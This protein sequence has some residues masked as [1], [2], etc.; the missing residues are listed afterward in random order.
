MGLLLGRKPEH[1]T[2]CFPFEVAGGG[3]EGQLLCEAVLVVWLS[4]AAAACVILLSFAAGHRKSYWSGCIKAAILICQ[5]IFSILVLMIFFL[6]F[7]E[8]VR[9]NRVFLLWRQDPALELQFLTPLQFYCVLQFNISISHCNGCG[10][11]AWCRGCMRNTIVFCS[12]TSYIALEWLHQGCDIDL[13]AEFLNFG[14]DDF[15]FL[16]PFKK[17]FKFFFRSGAGTHP[18]LELQFLLSLC[19][20]TFL[21]VK[22]SL[23]KSLQA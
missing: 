5:Q 15:P 14:V 19:T 12:W 10:K 13:S 18:I 2:L 1:E 23:C 16:I 17:C 4:G 8:K 3:D 6:K 21:R 11:V 22:T 7:L 9:Q 20:K